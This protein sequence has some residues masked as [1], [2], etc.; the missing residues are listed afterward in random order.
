MRSFAALGFGYDSNE[1]IVHDVVDLSALTPTIRSGCVKSLSLF[2][3]IS[4]CAYTLRPISRATWLAFPPASLTMKCS[5]TGFAVTD[6]A[7]LGNFGVR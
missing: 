7:K 6:Q 2:Q 3:A 4:P 1:A 5:T